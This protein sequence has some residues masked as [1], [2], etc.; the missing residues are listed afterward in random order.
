M[1]YEKVLEFWHITEELGHSVDNSKRTHFTSKDSKLEKEPHY[2]IKIKIK[3]N[4]QNK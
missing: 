4:G 1:W 3:K 2:K